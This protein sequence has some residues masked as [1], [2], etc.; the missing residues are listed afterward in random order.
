ML[1][2]EIQDTSDSKTILGLH[3]KGFNPSH[4]MTPKTKCQISAK[5]FSLIYLFFYLMSQE[6]L[7]VTTEQILHTKDKS[8][9]S[10][11]ASLSWS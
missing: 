10:Q 4:Y 5:A 1:S 2:P 9:I 6:I 7:Y 3:R 8:E 11:L